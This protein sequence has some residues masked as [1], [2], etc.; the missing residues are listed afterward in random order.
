MQG[1][2]N[3][4]KLTP[5]TRERLR[6]VLKNPDAFVVE[7]FKNF[8]VSG[9]DYGEIVFFLYI[10][11]KLG[12]IR[13]LKKSLPKEAVSLIVAILLNRILKPTSKMER[14]EWI[15]NTVFPLSQLH[16]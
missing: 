3:I 6:V 11:H 2:A 12:V 10:M 1:F 13:V 7:S 4:D 15:K 14:V 9:Y 16:K 5:I 8:F